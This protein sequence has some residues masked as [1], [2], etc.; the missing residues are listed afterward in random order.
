MSGKV[1][2]PADLWTQGRLPEPRPE[3]QPKSE[4][5]SIPAEWIKQYDVTPAHIAKWLSE[6]DPVYAKRVEIINEQRSRNATF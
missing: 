1:L 6:H 2:R 3:P 4:F 5:E